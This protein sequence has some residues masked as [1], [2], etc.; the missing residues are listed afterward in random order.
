MAERAAVVPELDSNE[1]VSLTATTEQ[2]LSQ[3][4]EKIHLPSDARNEG[5]RNGYRPK[6]QQ[7]RRS[8]GDG[9]PAMDGTACSTRTATFRLLAR[10]AG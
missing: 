2:V 3:G 10:A 4:Q 9:R 7:K 5:Q 8:S 1:T 6:D